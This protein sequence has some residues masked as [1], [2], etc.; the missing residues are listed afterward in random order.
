[1]GVKTIKQHLALTTIVM[2]CTV[3]DAVQGFHL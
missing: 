3:H 1:M 2:Q